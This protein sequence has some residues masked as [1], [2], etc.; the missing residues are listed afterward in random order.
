MSNEV[1]LEDLTEEELSALDSATRFK[2]NGLSEAAGFKRVVD[3]FV[4]KI[5]S[6][7]EEEKLLLDPVTD[8]DAIAEIDYV[9]S[10]M[11]ALTQNIHQFIDAIVNRIRKRSYTPAWAR[12]YVAAKNALAGL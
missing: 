1:L 3:R 2:A 11:E 9:L 10:Q 12:W 7:L 8:A 6:N 5:R 4:K